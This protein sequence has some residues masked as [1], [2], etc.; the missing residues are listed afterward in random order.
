MMKAPSRAP[1]DPRPD[2]LKRIGKNVRTCRRDRGLTQEGLADLLGVS[3]SYVSLIERGGRNP[4][5]TTMVAI[6]DVL[7]VSPAELVA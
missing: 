6:A 5:V 1:H 7:G 2:V 3:T 4:P